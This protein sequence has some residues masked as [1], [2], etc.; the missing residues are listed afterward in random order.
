MSAATEATRVIGHLTAEVRRAVAAHPE[1]QRAIAAQMN[2]PLPTFTRRLSGATPWHLPE[3]A[4]LATV[5]G[6]TAAD[7]IHRAEQAVAK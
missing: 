3:L 4:A 2:M 7:L 5:L 1:S 6:C